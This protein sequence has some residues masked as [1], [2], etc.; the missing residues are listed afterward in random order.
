MPCDKCDSC[1]VDVLIR[2]I[3]NKR[4]YYVD[5]VTKGSCSYC[6]MDKELEG[7]ELVL[8]CSVTNSF[9]NEKAILT[10]LDHKNIV[11]MVSSYKNMM[12]FEPCYGGTLGE[13]YLGGSKILAT[14]T[15]VC[16]HLRDIMSALDYLHANDIAHLDIK[17]DN[18]LLQNGEVKLSDFDLAQRWDRH[19]NCRIRQCCLPMSPSEIGTSFI[20]GFTNVNGSK[21][22][23]W[24]AGAVML[25]I[26]TRRLPWLCAKDSEKDYI[27]WVN[28]TPDG[29]LVKTL[30][31]RSPNFPELMRFILKHAP[32]SR[33]TASQVLEKVN[34]F[35]EKQQG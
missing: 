14:F 25:M 29:R 17:P 33:P 22:D 1:M 27:D 15:N 11:K 26:I 9:E 23:I 3:S 12:Y 16:L 8:K 24:S 31:E 13:K 30:S 34:D 7:R 5:L 10:G 2:E 19:G 32:E 21:A 6:G 35:L 20:T 4:K 28:E 18:C